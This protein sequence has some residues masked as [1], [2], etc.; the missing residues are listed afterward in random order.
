MAGF[1]GT[2]AAGSSQ[3][4]LRLQDKAQLGEHTSLAT[5]GQLASVNGIHLA[6]GRAL[7]S[8]GNASILG[9]FTNNGAVSGSGGALTFLNDVNGAGSYAGNVIFRAGYSPGNS[10]STIHHGGGDV[11]FDATSVLTME[12][13]GNAAGSQH[14]Q[15][16]GINNLSFNGRLSVVFGNGF[17]PSSASFQLFSFQSFAGSFAPDRIDVSGFDRAR[18]DFSQLGQDGTL[19]VTAVPEPGS[20]AM[21][22]AG[23]GLMG[24]MVWRWRGARVALG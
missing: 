1:A 3:A 12:I 18:L 19:S 5:G 17:A 16:A 23:L 6:T 9:T 15:L 21:M 13:L 2:L 14:D 7:T 10:P 8:N 11:T 24:F 22:L 4:L 20:Y